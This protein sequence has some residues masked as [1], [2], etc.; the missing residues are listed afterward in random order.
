MPIKLTLTVDPHPDGKGSKSL[1]AFL[2]VLS[3]AVTVLTPVGTIVT[4]FL[5]HTTNVPA[6]ILAVYVCLLT[7][8]LLWLLIMQDRRQHRQLM[9]QESRHH[10][11]IVDQDSRH[12]E[13][14]VEQ[15]KRFGRAF[16]YAPAMIPI[17]KAFGS[18]SGASWIM[19][20]GDK[21]KELFIEHLRHSLQFMAEAFG[22]IT[23]GPCRFSIKMMSTLT[24]G[25]NVRDARVFTLCRSDEEDGNFAT[26]YDTVGNNT[27]F[28]QILEDGSAYYFCPD[29]PAE[30]AK[31][32]YQNSHWTPQII[33]TQAYKYR[34]TIVWPISRARARMEQPNGQKGENVIGFLCLDTPNTNSLNETYDVPVG[35]AFA[36]VLYLALK[37]FGAVGSAQS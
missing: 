15:E 5:A 10:Q 9:D 17:R 32:L 37:Q 8:L 23:D 34:E 6:L 2:G 25:V 21:S 29:L 19:F 11:Q 16:Q 12:H 24:E 18:L 22:L 35:L 31:G 26:A 3:A 13:Q 36:G 30:M 27:D 28:R 33:R 20:E 1:T 4:I 7:S 14:I